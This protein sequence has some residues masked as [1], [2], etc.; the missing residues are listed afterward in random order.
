MRWT[1]IIT[2]AALLLGAAPSH[3]QWK[4]SPQQ[5]VVTEL[6]FPGELSDTPEERQA[7]ENLLQE[8][9]KFTEEH[10]SLDGVALVSR[11]AYGLAVKDGKFVSGITMPKNFFKTEKDA[12]AWMRLGAIAQIVDEDYQ[13]EVSGEELA[14][15]F[16]KGLHTLDPHSAYL[17]K[18]DAAETEIKGQGQFAGIGAEV[19]YH[20]GDA[21]SLRGVRV[22][23]PL[24]GSPAEKAGLKPKDVILRIC[25]ET[26]DE[27]C[28][29]TQSAAYVLTDI[30]E[31]ADPAVE[32][33]R[34]APDTIVHVVVWRKG[35][36]DWLHIPITRGIVSL[37][38]VKDEAIKQGTRGAYGYAHLTSF[39]E[40][41]P[42]QLQQAFDRLDEQHRAVTGKPLDGFVLDLRGNLGGVLSATELMLDDLLQ[43]TPYSK[44]A[45][46]TD[47][48]TVIS[49]ESR[50]TIEQEHTSCHAHDY[51]DGRPMTILVNGGSA[52]ASEITAGVLQYRKRAVIVGAEKT[53]GKGTVQ[54]VIPLGDGAIKITTQQ[55]MLGAKGCEFPIQQIGVTPD[56]WVQD[57]NPEQIARLGE[58][59]LAHSIATSGRTAESCQYRFELPK[60]HLEAAHDMVKAM[61][62]KAVEP[63]KTN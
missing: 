25:S 9:R 7:W 62:L 49:T 30:M 36:S 1:I 3:A 33:L 15:A 60:G 26:K 5:S 47:A 17:Q 4:N 16:A 35:S 27:R 63:P 53:F 8:M 37:A 20:Y 22:V 2:V 6:L 39:S 56:I 31:N 57:E 51:L 21:E 18:K 44:D 45:C 59:H 52:S 32:L 34:G 58:R 46:D 13:R 14:G 12:Q 50:G 40:T 54:N 29:D 11:L 38:F 23:S 28:T 19:E 55:Y 10:P 48:E 24:P 61:G 43:S 41:S 42:K